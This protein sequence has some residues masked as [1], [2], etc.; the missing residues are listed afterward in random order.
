[1]GTAGDSKIPSW[2]D[3]A[4][5]RPAREP[6]VPDVIGAGFTHGD[7]GRFPV[8]QAGAFEAGGTADGMAPCSVLAELTG[9]VLEAGLGRLSDDELV[10]VLRAAR[11]VVSWQSAVELAAVD[12]LAARRA[13][14]QHDAGP[15]PVERASAELA[16][17]LTLTGRAADMLLDL[18][19][20]VTRLPDVA[21]ALSRGDIDPARAGV[22]AE[23]LASLPWLPASV[24]AGRQ[25]LAAPGLTTSQLRAVL[26]R[27]VL[28]ADPAAGRRRQREARRD[29]RVQ[30]WAEASGNGAIAG[31]ELPP[32]QA[33]L[34]DKHISAL[35]RSLQA[36]GLPG[37]FDQARA[38]V[39]IALLSGQSPQSLL[40]ARL[41]EPGSES[42]PEP[43]GSAPADRAGA[44]PATSASGGEPAASPGLSGP[45]G[46]GLSGTGLSWPAGPLGT[47]HL[48]VPLSTWLSVTDRPGEIA[49]YG[50]ADAWTCRE[51]AGTMTG[52]SGTRY[53]LTITTPDGHPL[54]HA[55]TSTPPPG[56]APPGPVLPG[57]RQAGPAPPG[58]SQAG[59]A[60]PGPPQPG[61][62]GTDAAAWIAGL[63]MEW[64]EAGSCGHSRQAPGYR[65]SRLLDHLI[66]IR[67]PTCTAPGCRRPAQQ[68]DVDHVIPYDQGGFT[69][70]C[71]CHPACRRHHRCK[72][73]SGWHLEM[74]E[75]G[76]LTWHLPH[77]RLYTTRAEPYPV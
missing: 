34:A 7:E 2:I 10:G 47:I 40:A 77:G 57:S 55:C 39:F 50:P 45:S 44:E 15:H 72:G 51:L 26:R 54:G 25:M 76:V 16:A 6:T 27:A 14:E 59:P 60:P 43:A 9:Q 17:A 42:T 21:A 67:N 58:P 24:I 56:P 75:P 18:A 3:V 69:C 41:A 46:T 38:E 33:L 5:A 52:Q 8:P 29:A 11:R 53:C 61:L 35:A 22:F 62:R 4:A 66:K 49:G 32:S 28:A 48:T 23:E 64:L 30:A 68:C 12:E 70:E 1:M 19:S 73:T 13:A 74:P 71:N 31:R 36:A 65:P 20:G 37:T 63:T